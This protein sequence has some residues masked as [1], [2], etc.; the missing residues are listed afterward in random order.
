MDATVTKVERLTSHVLDRPFIRSFDVLSNR[1]SEPRLIAAL[2]FRAAVAHLV[3]K[4][5]IRGGDWE[6]LRWPKAVV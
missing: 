6:C 3:L 5:G 2:R 1:V 4:D